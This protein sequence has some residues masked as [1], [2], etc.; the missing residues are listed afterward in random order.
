MASTLDTLYLA[1]AA[2]LLFWLLLGSLCLW[3]LPLARW[4]FVALL[5]L[6]MSVF[7]HATVSADTVTD[8]VAFVSVAFLLRLAYGPG[9]MV[10]WGQVG[11]LVVLAGCLASAKLVYTPLATHRV[12]C[13]QRP[14]CGPGW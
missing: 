4:L 8:S 3:L 14:V 7:T 13:A 5:L 9:V 2:G 1:R 11:A 10:R 6:P 12:T